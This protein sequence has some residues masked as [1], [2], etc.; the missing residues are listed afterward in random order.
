MKKTNYQVRVSA[1]LSA[2]AFAR[3]ECWA[4]SVTESFYVGK[5][6]YAFD[7]TIYGVTKA[8]ATKKATAF[9]ATLQA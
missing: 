3:V 1:A 7:H 5:K 8:D 4:C 6:F 2:Y 9:A